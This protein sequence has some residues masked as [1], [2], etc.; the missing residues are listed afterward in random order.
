MNKF[1]IFILSIFVFVPI[2]DANTPKWDYYVDKYDKEKD[3]IVTITCKRDEYFYYCPGEEKKPIEDVSSPK[4][5]VI[6][7]YTNKKHY[8]ILEENGRTTIKEGQ[9]WIK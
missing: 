2:V 6:Y 3:N 7:D 4:R 5:K 1:I 9:Y 8:T